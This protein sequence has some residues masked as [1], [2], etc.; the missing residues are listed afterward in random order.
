MWYPQH[1]NI[2]SVIDILLQTQ[3]IIRDT[4][5][6]VMTMSYGYLRIKEETRKLWDQLK[7]ELEFR[8]N[9]NLT[10]DD[11]LR[12]IIDCINKETVVEMIRKTPDS[13]KIIEEV[14][15]NE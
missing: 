11:M 5:K 3:H 4:T 8:S 6:V 2:L 15:A 10:H 1:L 9:A 12:V 13:Q 7:R 14:E